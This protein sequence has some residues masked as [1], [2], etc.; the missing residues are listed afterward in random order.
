MTRLWLSASTTTSSAMGMVGSK[1][2][3]GKAIAR[4]LMVIAEWALRLRRGRWQA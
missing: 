1:Q 2:V 4:S 3:T